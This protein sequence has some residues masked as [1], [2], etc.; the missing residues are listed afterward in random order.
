MAPKA[1]A[2]WPYLV[3]FAPTMPFE[4]RAL[5]G[6]G[7]DP[8]NFA[9]LRMPALFLVG[10]QTAAELG[11]VLRQLRPAMPQAEWAVFEGQGHGAMMRAP[12]MFTDTVLAFLAGQGQPLG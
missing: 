4:G 1:T 7:F 9:G 12:Q 3:S 2:F 6:Y 10:S 11:E 5:V 8:A